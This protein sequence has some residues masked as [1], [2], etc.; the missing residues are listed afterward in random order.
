[1]INKVVISCFLFGSVSMHKIEFISSFF[2]KFWLISSK[3]LKI[4]KIPVFSNRLN[5]GIFFSDIFKFLVT[6]YPYIF[7]QL[8]FLACLTS[9][10]S[11]SYMNKPRIFP[12]SLK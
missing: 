4:A 2:T 6:I 11:M 8:L 3:V 9:V 5:A 12:K 1:M 10:S 7:L